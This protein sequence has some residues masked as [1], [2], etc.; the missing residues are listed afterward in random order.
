MVLPKYGEVLEPILESP[1]ASELF[2]FHDAAHSVY[3]RVH[4]GA[5]IDSGVDKIQDL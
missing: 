2:E 4:V 3:L 1:L 5:V